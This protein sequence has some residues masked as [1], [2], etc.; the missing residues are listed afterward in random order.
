[1]SSRQTGGKLSSHQ[2][3]DDHIKTFGDASYGPLQTRRLSKYRRKINLKPKG[4]SSAS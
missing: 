3:C 2:K 1:L 4:P